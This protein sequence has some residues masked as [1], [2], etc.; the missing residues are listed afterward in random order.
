MI[1][2]YNQS[3]QKNHNL[4]WPYITDHPYRI[5]IICDSQLEKAIA[6]LNL[7]KNQESDIKKTYLYIKDPFKLK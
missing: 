6:L 5:L 4:N 2:N 1:K 7:I 3:V